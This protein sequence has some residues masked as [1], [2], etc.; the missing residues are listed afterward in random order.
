MRQAFA[1]QER[2][3]L[4]GDARGGIRCVRELIRDPRD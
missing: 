3:V 1:A 4:N 2:S